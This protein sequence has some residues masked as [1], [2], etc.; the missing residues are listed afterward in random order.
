[1]AKKTA[2][3]KRAGRSTT[4][5]RKTTK[6]KTAQN[7][8][9]PPI[10]IEEAAQIAKRVRDEAALPMTFAEDADH[11]STARTIA[12]WSA[13]LDAIGGWDVA[14]PNLLRAA[15]LLGRLARAFQ[16]FRRP[17]STVID[18]DQMR[19]ARAV[20]EEACQFHVAMARKKAPGTATVSD[21]IAC[22]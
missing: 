2:S 20:M 11:E 18:L 3:W 12:Q 14:R 13:N 4:T 17:E 9:A 1:M 19:K 5:I 6:R 8:A 22:A 15:T 16:E 10:S 21:G 7:A